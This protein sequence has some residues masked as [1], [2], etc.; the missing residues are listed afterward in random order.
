MKNVKITLSSVLI[1]L[2]VLPFASC[3]QN[4]VVHRAVRENLFTLEIGRMED[5]IALYNLDGDMGLRRVNMAM[6][7]GL[8]YISDGLGGKIVRY[9]SY[10]D[11]L[12]MI[13]N[14]ETNPM[15]V[16]LKPLQDN[17]LVTR[18]AV[19]YPL[20]EPGEITVD[21]RNHIYVRDRL[22]NEK[23]SVDPESKALMDN[24]IL[25]F[26]ENGRFVEYLGRNG[27]G[28]SPFPRIEGLFISVQ[29]EL[30]VV[31]RLPLGWEIYWFR[32][33]G[34]FLYMVK[35]NNDA[36]PVP[37]D[38]DLVFASLN[39]I[40]AAP[41]S[42]RLYVKV[43]YYRETFDGSTNIRTGNE[44]DSSTAWIMNIE[45]GEWEKWIEIPFYE[46]TYTENNRRNS[47]Y[48]PYSMTGII[49]GGRLFLSLPVDDGYSLIFLNP[50]AGS[51]GE[52][53][54]CIIQVDYDELLY[55]VFVL[56]AEGL[57]SALLLD[58][59]KVKIV[60]WRTDKFIGEGS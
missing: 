38:R 21:S 50:D 40:A 44:Y 7:D 4:G 14:E 54:K 9:N 35:I 16:S 34:A 5:Q 53:R 11:L 55:N 46:Y 17:R 12:F 43:D 57:L 1:L 3:K 31:C 18:W 49:S 37:P 42:R 2:I 47:V 39:S 60:W 56:S 24:V 52:D 59:W 22:P 19:S 20:N 28:G 13:Y 51:V 15:P 58:E 10:G 45:N 8:F 36:V 6:R 25:H 27:I 33:D 32:N 30:A 26:D 48:L 41:D 29:D 23:H